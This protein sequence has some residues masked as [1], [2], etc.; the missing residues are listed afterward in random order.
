MTVK[1]VRLS[2]V[3]VLLVSVLA[4]GGYIYLQATR[5]PVGIYVATRDLPAYHQITQADVRRIMVSAAGAP[6]NAISDRE[7]LLDHYTL[8]SIS[9][10]GAFRG[11]MLGPRLMTG[12][13]HG[14]LIVALRSSAETT[15][16]G[17]IGRGDLVDMLL[18]ATSGAHKVERSMMLRSILILDVTSNAVIVG[19]KSQDEKSL[20]DGIG[21]SKI[22]FART[23]PYV[24]P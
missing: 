7:R 8:K 12:A 20:E 5:H 13:L 1:P 22:V 9:Q 21:T 15:L 10:G 3:A 2:L 4:V 17:R 14:F 18:S 6:A 16:G 11:H 23:S 19:I 24:E